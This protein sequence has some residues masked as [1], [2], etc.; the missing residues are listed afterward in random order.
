[1]PYRTIELY[2][3]GAHRI[4][5]LSAPPIGCAI[6]E[7]S[8]WRIDFKVMNRGCCGTGKLEVAV[9]CNPLDATGSNASECVLEQ[10]SS[11]KRRL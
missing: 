5:V 2:N 6:T 11:N 4:G 9:L 8:G 1:M 10:L 3:L 7:N